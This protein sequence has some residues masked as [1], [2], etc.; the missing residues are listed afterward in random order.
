MSPLHAVN[1]PVFLSSDKLLANSI[2]TAVPELGSTAPKTQASLWFPNITC[3]SINLRQ[4]HNS[5]MMN[6]VQH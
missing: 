3:L 5:I 1:L 4:V 6:R 2:K